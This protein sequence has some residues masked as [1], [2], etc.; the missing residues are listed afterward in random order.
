[1]FEDT[2]THT[3]TFAQRQVSVLAS[4]GR[5]FTFAE[6][7]HH[8]VTQY[9][10]LDRVTG[11]RINAALAEGGRSCWGLHGHTSLRPLPKSFCW[12]LLQL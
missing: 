1:M 12:Q 4:A 10:I 2:L 7:Q 9:V 11:T 3:H 6:Q 5:G 8:R